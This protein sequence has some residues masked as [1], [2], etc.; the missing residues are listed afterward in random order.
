MDEKKDIW[1]GRRTLVNHPAF[2]YPNTKPW[3]K[4]WRGK[5]RT[6]SSPVINPGAAHMPWE[7]LIEL[8]LAKESME[9]IAFIRNPIDRVL[10]ALSFFFK[11]RRVDF[12]ESDFSYFWDGYLADSD[13]GRI[14]EFKTRG[15]YTMEHQHS[16][17]NDNPTV[18]KLENFGPRITEL[19]E[20]CGGTV[21]EVLHLNKSE[22]RPPNDQLLTKERQQQILEFYQDD[23]ILWEKAT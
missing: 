10:S 19:V 4:P 15:A 1:Q 22:E 21:K 9:C 11:S 5:L 16:F 23:F 18:Y 14:D 3:Q 20:R 13:E 7:L 12:Q 8:E 17:L 2:L 6:T